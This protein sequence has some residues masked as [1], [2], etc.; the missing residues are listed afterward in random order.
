MKSYQ[1]WSDITWWTL[2]ETNTQIVKKLIGTGKYLFLSF[3]LDGHT[4][5]LRHAQNVIHK[6]KE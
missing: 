4:Y 2:L 5:I 1:N 6:T 3:K